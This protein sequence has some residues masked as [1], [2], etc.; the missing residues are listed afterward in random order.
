MAYISRNGYY[1][2]INNHNSRNN[3]EKQ[4]H[5]DFKLILSAY[6]Y[7]GYD[8]GRR[9]IYMRLLHISVKMNQK[10]LVALCTNTI[11]SVRFAKQI[12]IEGWQ[13]L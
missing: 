12:H 10:K 2:W 3:K 6:Q 9:G 8:K 1:N 7:R 4:D 11:Y 13:R 5:A